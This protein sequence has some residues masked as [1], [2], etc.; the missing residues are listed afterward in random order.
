[1]GEHFCVTPDDLI[2][3]AWSAPMRDLA[4]K[5]GMSDV[6]LR[7][8]LRGHG[9]ATPAQGY[10]NRVHAVRKVPAR[11]RPP[12][13]G[14]GSSDRIRLDPRF[15][16]LIPDAGPFPV[17]G[18]FASALVPES[19]DE[20]RAAVRT[21]ISRVGVPQLK[22][23]HHPALNDL[24]RRE[25]RRREKHARDRWADPPQFDTPY[26]QRQ[27]R[28]FNALFLALARHGGGGSLHDDAG[29]MDARARVG[30]TVMTLVLEPVGRVRT[31]MRAG[32]QRPAA[33]LPARTP[34][35]L[36][37]DAG[38]RREPFARHADDDTGTLEQ[39]LPDIVADVMTA[40][41]AA[42][43]RGLREQQEWIEQ[44][45][46]MR[47]EAEMRERAAVESARGERL[48]AHAAALREADDIRTLVARVAASCGDTDPAALAAWSAWALAR[49]D[50]LDP[51]TSGR[52]FAEFA[53]TR[54]LEPDLT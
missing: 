51:V 29:R 22:N 8:L 14:P 49:A 1:M 47:A 28:L 20:L 17:N 10:W 48:K 50:R 3:F 23:G 12:A 11:P 21:K 44:S 43:R 19:L 41:E 24:I 7:K 4:A 39:K 37:I 42:F 9:V 5:V 25:T 15:A 16:G 18:P 26:W 30:D 13:R 6:G 31:E 53:V 54:G 45:I 27:L 2:A 34:L 33:D 35:A 52:M 36:L 46:R 40:G 32:R 38:H